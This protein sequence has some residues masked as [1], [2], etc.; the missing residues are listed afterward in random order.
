MNICGTDDKI[1]LRSLVLVLM[2]MVCS[3]SSTLNLSL[4][5]W[6]ARDLASVACLGLVG[7]EGGEKAMPLLIALN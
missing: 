3:F 6:M 4:A 7:N 1:M 2:K 5:S